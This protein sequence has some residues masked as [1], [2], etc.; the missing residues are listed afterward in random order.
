MSRG[1]LTTS[2]Q[3][4]DRLAWIGRDGPGRHTEFGR[5]LAREGQ[6]AEARR[7]FRRSLALAP[8]ARG[9]Q[10]LGLLHEQG[11]EWTLAATAYD[12]A[13]ALKPDDVS[14]VFRAGRA[15]LES[16]QAARAVPLLERAAGMAP[17]ENL[18][19]LNLARA[20]REVDALKEQPGR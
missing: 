5:R 7:E 17:E 19:A 12:S 18:I 6:P 9:F 15:W 20:R 14:T 16:G 1:D 3:A 2:R 8:T 13:L 11:L 10:S 4:L